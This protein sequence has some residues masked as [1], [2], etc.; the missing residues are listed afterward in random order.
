VRA[1]LQSGCRLVRLRTDWPERTRRQSDVATEKEASVDT[2][3]E[4]RGYRE[5]GVCGHVDRATWL[6]RDAIAPWAPATGKGWKISL[7]AGRT[8]RM[9]SCLNI[10]VVLVLSCINLRAQGKIDLQSSDTIHAVLERNAG[11][12]VELRL[13]SGEKIGGRV[14]KLGDKLVHL[15]QLSGA[16]FYDAAVALDDVEAVVVRVQK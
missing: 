7:A 4:R 6:Q 8:G 11:Q 9:K 13:Q 16:E 12:V 10:F 14:Q 3:T 2:S 1:S 15:T 5:R